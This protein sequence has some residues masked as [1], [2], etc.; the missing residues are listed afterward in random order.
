MGTLSFLVGIVSVMT[1]PLIPVRWVAAPGPLSGAAGRGAYSAPPRRASQRNVYFH[2][3]VAKQRRKQ[4][5]TAPPRIAPGSAFGS[6]GRRVTR[7]EN[8]NPAQ[9]SN[10]AG[11]REPS[12]E[13]IEIISCYEG[14]ACE[15]CR[16][17]RG[18]SGNPRE[19]HHLFIRSAVIVSFGPTMRLTE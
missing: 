6:V 15:T 5:H 14:S 8:E 16:R 1:Q 18:S 10:G 3:A 13:C 11:S 7:P 19:A 12:V 17:H 2:A 4:L 9:A